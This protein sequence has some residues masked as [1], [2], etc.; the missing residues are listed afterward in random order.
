[1]SAMEEDIGANRPLASVVHEKHILEK[2]RRS[3]PDARSGKLS[4][5][6]AFRRYC[7]LSP[8]LNANLAVE[9]TI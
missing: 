5:S 3:L 6:D 2:N 8:F 4:H 1:M 9:R 7:L